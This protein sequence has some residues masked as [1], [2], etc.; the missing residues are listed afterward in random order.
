MVPSSDSGTAVIMGS[1]AS[2]LVESE[3]G[4]M[5][6]NDTDAEDTMKRKSIDKCLCNQNDNGS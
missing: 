3:L 6:I 4:T 5:V 1:E 2:T